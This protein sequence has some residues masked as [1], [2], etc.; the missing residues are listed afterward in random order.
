MNSPILVP[1]QPVTEPGVSASRRVYRCLRQRIVEMRMLPGERIIER[2]LAEEL[3]VSRTPVHEAVLRLA[4]EGLIEIV[5]RSG[6]FVARIPLGVLEEGIL[7]RRALETAIIAQATQRFT[8]K[9]AVRLRRI[10]GQQVAAVGSNDTRAFHHT[11]EM[12][13]AALAEL[14]GYPGVWPIIQ[15]AKTQMDRYRQL[16]LPLEGRMQN[17]LIEHTEIMIAIES[18][19]PTCAVR[20]MRNHLDHVLPMLEFTR[21]MRPEYFSASSSTIR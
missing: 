6:T 17:V 10:L 5:P 12:F 8:P 1:A 16:T 19:D 3:G 9:G 14:S 20:A 11:D 2:D 13:H 21:T 18:R 15:Q 7:V 4:D